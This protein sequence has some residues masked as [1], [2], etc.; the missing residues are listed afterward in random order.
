[1]SRLRTEFGQV[2]T[3]LLATACVSV[4]TS[5]PRRDEGMDAPKSKSTGASGR[6]GQGWLARGLSSDDQV[7]A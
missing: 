4:A 6:L 2:A 3:A 7:Q 1:M 5:A